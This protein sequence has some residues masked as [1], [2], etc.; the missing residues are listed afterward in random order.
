MVAMPYIVVNIVAD[1]L[2]L[3]LFCVSSAALLS[4]YELISR[5]LPAQ[6]RSH[7]TLVF[8]AH[9]LVLAVLSMIVVRVTTRGTA[10]FIFEMFFYIG[11][12]NSVVLTYQFLNARYFHNIPKVQRRLLIGACAAVTTSAAVFAV[13]TSVVALFAIR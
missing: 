10:R 13:T 9:V 4:K 2:S 7:R 11:F 1:L 5:Y 6:W 3:M 12:A 8:V